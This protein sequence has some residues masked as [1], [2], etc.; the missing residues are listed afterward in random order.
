[1]TLST[2][3]AASKVN[4]FAVLQALSSGPVD[5]QDFHHFCPNRICALLSLFVIEED[6]QI[7][8]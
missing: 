2:S 7:V 1:M 6:N 8:I 4:F 5:W 3:L